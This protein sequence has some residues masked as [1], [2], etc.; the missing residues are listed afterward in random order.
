ML[1]YLV[2]KHLPAHLIST[3]LCSFTGSMLTVV[4]LS[5]ICGDSAS[6]AGGPVD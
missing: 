3:V 2:N 5:L 6:R 1:V 4:S